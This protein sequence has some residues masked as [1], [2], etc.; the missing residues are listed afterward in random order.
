MKYQVGDLVRYQGFDSYSHPPL[1]GI[2]IKFSSET[3]VIHWLKQN[4]NVTSEY[5]L[6]ELKRYKNLSRS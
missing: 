1:Y 6:E 5:L 4:S 2:I 3:Y